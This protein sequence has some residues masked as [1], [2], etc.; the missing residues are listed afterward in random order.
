MVS[1]IKYFSTPLFTNEFYTNSLAEI[2]EPL[3]LDF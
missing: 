2:T 3:T 1:N